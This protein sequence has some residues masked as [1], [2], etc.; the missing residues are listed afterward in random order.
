MRDVAGM[1]ALRGHRPLVSASTSRR[2]HAGT[3]SRTPSAR[4]RRP[5]TDVKVVVASATP[6]DPASIPHDIEDRGV[7]TRIDQERNP[8]VSGNFR[9]SPQ[10]TESA[11]ST[12]QGGDTGSTVGTTVKRHVSHIFDKL[13]ASTRTQAVARARELGLIPSAGR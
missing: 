2:C 5:K 4:P 12:A 1:L 7:A 6:F 11:G 8:P 3:C 13:S 9:R 10:V